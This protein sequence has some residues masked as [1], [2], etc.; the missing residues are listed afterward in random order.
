MQEPSL[1]AIDQFQPKGDRHVGHATPPLQGWKSVR[2]FGLQF[3]RL[4]D[5]HKEEKQL[6]LGQG[7]PRAD[8]LARRERD[9]AL[10]SNDSPLLVE[11]A[12]RIEPVP[13]LPV[14][15]PLQ[16]GLVIGQDEVSPWYLVTADLVV[17]FFTYIMK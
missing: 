16:E 17:M 1:F 5:S 10:V 4:Q 14:V 3:E 2:V 15:V 12:L 11:K 13:L 8:P 9:E 7:L 6:S